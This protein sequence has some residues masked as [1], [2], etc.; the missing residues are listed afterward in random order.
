MG[1]ERRMLDET[2]TFYDVCN[3]FDVPKGSRKKLV[4]LPPEVK[5]I[6]LKLN[7]KKMPLKEAIKNLQSVTGHKIEIAN[8]HNCINL[9][10][11][12]SNG[13]KNHLRIIRYI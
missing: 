3:G 4:F 6:A 12:D 5:K 10:I 7:G 11:V 2:K 13:V 8:E 1:K 9:V